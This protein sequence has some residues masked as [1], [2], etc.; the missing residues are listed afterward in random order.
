MKL[1]ELAEIYRT[2]LAILADADLPPQA[3]ADTL[4]AIQGDLTDKIRAVVAFAREQRA[5]GEARAAVAKT[6]TAS[7]KT[8]L[9]RAD[10]LEEYALD[11]VRH[12]GLALPLVYTDMTV[13]IA[14]NPPSVF[15]DEEAMLKPK[16]LP[17]EFWEEETIVKI[18]RAEILRALK[19][20]QEIPHAKI[21]ETTYRLKVT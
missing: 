19:E 8:I 15:L 17:E 4:E 18:K 16:L 9:N 2:E 21:A 3:V 13:G 14:K 20:G 6:M 10:W 12:C 11:T 7:A 1:Y 5:L